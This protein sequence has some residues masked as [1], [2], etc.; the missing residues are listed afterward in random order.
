MATIRF[1]KS[2]SVLKTCV[3]AWI[4]TITK[5][6]K[7]HRTFDDTTLVLYTVGW[8]PAQWT[9]TFYLEKSPFQDL[10]K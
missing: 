8:K 1:L 10:F 6:E 9:I 5:R 7:Y 2:N 4:M 3:C